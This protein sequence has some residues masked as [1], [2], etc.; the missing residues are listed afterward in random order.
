MRAL[1]AWILICSALTAHAQQ[2]A[3]PL[4][5]LHVPAQP[6]ARAADIQIDLMVM[7]TDTEALAYVPPQELAGTLQVEQR[8]WIV[9][10][11]AAQPSPTLTIEPGK[12]AK[13]TYQLTLPGDATGRVQLE[14]AQLAATRAVF[15]IRQ[16]SA[17]NESSLETLAETLKQQEAAAP[18]ALSRIERT[19]ANRFGFHDP[20][21]F[22]YGAEAPAAKFQF[23]FKYR[24]IGANSK[25]GDLIPPFRG[26]YFGYTQR[27]LWDLE[28]DSS[29]FFDT[30][31]MP[32][33]FFEWLAPEYDKP[34]GWF[35]FLGIQTGAR[36]E[37]NGKAGDESRSLNNL[38]LRSGIVLGSLTGW[39]LLVVP[40]VFSYT[41][42]AEENADIKRYR[43]YGELQL[44]LTKNDSFQVGITTHVGS[45]GNK[46]NIQVNLT[47]P[48]K[49]PWINLETYL[50]LQYFD[51]YGESLRTFNEK[52]TIWRFG[53][54]FVR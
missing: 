25:F 53:L 18:P 48:V 40:R 38:Y 35:H 51:G 22:L 36:H 14:V 17:A 50:Q 32:E 6:P 54:S 45:T 49:I 20:I 30:S 39:H 11:H 7:N 33:L 44:A 21:Y 1:C 52:S 4:I 24:L 27:S 31:Y 2:T 41:G 47:Q 9:T 10:L 29:P 19:F 23:S 13:I 15:D 8:T 5:T 26:F 43:G 3:A 12:F 46:G 37:S 42:T 34:E 16:D 28:A